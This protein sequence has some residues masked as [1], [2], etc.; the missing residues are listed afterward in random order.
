MIVI[1]GYAP[2]AVLVPAVIPNSVAEVVIAIIIVI[3]L[4]TAWKGIE[5]GQHKGSTV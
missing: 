3:A 5:T 1:L 4:V 2:A